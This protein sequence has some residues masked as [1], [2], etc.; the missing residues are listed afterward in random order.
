[1]NVKKTLAALCL[2]SLA[3]FALTGCGSEETGKAKSEGGKVQMDLATAYSADSPAS[4]AM[5][6][7]V[8]DVKKNPTAALKSIYSPMEL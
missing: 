5:K 6:K 8:D 4:K 3:V 1:M 7:F 2:A